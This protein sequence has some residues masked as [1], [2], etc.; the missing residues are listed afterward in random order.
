VNPGPAV[1]RRTKGEA[2][3]LR[4]LAEAS[5]GTWPA[6]DAA[7]LAFSAACSP[8]RVL[9]LLDV[10]EAAEGM[11]EVRPSVKGKWWSEDGMV[12]AAVADTSLRSALARWREV[13][14]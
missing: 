3:D 14:R 2:V 1:R 6:Q 11:H 10:A 4:E 12:G 9:A 5:K 13:S 7:A 8:E